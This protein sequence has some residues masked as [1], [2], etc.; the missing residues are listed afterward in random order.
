MIP[1][2][3]LGPP[4]GIAQ[5]SCRLFY[6]WGDVN[7]C[8]LLFITPTGVETTHPCAFHFQ[9]CISYFESL[10]IVVFLVHND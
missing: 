4:A 8:D 1:V 2:H 9:T 3:S 10:I 5:V 6:A 7:E